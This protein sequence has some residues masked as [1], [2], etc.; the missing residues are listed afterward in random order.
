MDVWDIVEQG[1]KGLKH[2][3]DRLAMSALLRSVLKE[4]LTML[5]AK[6]T[7]KEAWDAVKSMRQGADCVKESYAHKLL[8]EFENIQFK[9]GELIDEF[10]M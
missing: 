2:A 4:M 5:G 3:H 8:K 1:G 6:K 10:G 9:N 7:V